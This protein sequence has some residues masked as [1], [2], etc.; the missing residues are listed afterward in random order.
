MANASHPENRLYPN[1][2]ILRFIFKERYE[3]NDVLRARQERR[4]KREIRRA[5]A[6]ESSCYNLIVDF[7]DPAFHSSKHFL[8]SS[9]IFSRN[10][11]MMHSRCFLDPAS[12]LN[13]RSKISLD[14]CVTLSC[15]VCNIRKIDDAFHSI[16]PSISAFRYNGLFFFFS[17][18]D[19]TT[20]P[21]SW[22]SVINFF[23]RPQ[24]NRM[25]SIWNVTCSSIDLGMVIFALK[26]L[27]PA[28]HFANTSSF[29]RIFFISCHSP[30]YK[31]FFFF[32]K[33]P[34]RYINRLNYVS[35]DIKLWI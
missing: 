11:I 31:V 29:L 19:V 33:F 17:L 22:F 23:R 13:F 14:F 7:S 27:N 30:S 25:P 1:H 2:T 32:F 20:M 9:R 21:V 6:S 15:N 24:D 3:I 34:V 12:H 28:F 18:V 26:R 16:D 10:C 35:A 4:R 8:L 5:R